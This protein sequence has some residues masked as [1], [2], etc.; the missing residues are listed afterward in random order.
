MGVGSVRLGT[1]NAV[2]WK[3]AFDVGNFSRVNEFGG[4]V[5]VLLLHR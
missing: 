2:T 5:N 3:L 4:V 1:A